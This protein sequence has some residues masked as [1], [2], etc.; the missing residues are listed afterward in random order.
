MPDGDRA[1]RHGPLTASV[2]AGESGAVIV[3]SGEADIT[4]A[5]QLRN[6]VEAW[7]CCGRG[8]LWPGCWR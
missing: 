7:S 2:A 1:V 4:C 5:G 3:P 6:A 8:S